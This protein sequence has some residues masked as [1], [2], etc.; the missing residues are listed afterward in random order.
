MRPGSQIYENWRKFPIPFY[1]DIYFF[2]WTNPEDFYNH[3]TKPI[4]K[5]VGPY[6]FQE[7]QEKINITWNPEN[8]TVS[9]KMM[10][11][12]FFD[13]EGSAGKL[14]DLITTVNIVSV[15]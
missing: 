6:R 1:I 4:F 5:E 12:F 2:N 14:S 10:S 8:S 15:V 3:S 7:N 13:E 11:T 9:Y